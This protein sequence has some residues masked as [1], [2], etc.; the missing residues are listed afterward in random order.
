MI[1]SLSY[2]PATEREI[3]PGTIE[4]NA[5]EIKAAPSPYKYF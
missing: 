5:A 4:I 2:E 3:Y 1:T